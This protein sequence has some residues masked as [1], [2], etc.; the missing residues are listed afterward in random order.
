MIESNDY[1]LQPQSIEWISIDVQNFSNT[2]ITIDLETRILN[3]STSSKTRKLINFY[4]TKYTTN[5][6]I[7]NKDN[8]NIEWIFTNLV[9][10]FESFSFGANNLI[11]KILSF[12]SEHYLQ[13][14]VWAALSTWST[15]I[16]W[17]TSTSMS[18]TLTCLGSNNLQLAALSS[19]Q[20]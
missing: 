3:N 20:H 18:I 14:C 17:A 9:V 8:Y 13:S 15:L 7:Q 6:F 10:I 19:K 1:K 16:P 11:F 12:L 2:R 5:L 4:L